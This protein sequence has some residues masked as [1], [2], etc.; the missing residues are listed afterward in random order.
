MFLFE[1]VG[2]SRKHGLPNYAHHAG[3]PLHYSGS[4]ITILELNNGPQSWLHVSFSVLDIDNPI[5]DFISKNIPTR[6]G[7]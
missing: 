4:Q 7:D 5:T 1:P 2:Q 6:P 3:Y